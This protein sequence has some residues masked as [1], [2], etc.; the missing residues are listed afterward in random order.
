MAFN[1]DDLI[2]D[3]PIRATLFDKTTSEVIFT[4]DQITDPSLECTTQTDEVRDAI[5][6]LVTELDRA[7]E[8]VFSGTNAFINLG[9]MASQLGTTKQLASASVKIQVPKFEMIELGAESGTTN[10]TI[11]LSETPVGDIKYIYRLGNNK[12]IA[13][14]YEAGVT[15][16]DTFAI[17]G[18]VITL[19]TTP[20]FSANDRFGV[21]Y[22]YEATGAEGLGAV[23]VSNNSEAFTKI[24]VFDLEVLLADVCN[25][26]I[27][28]YAHILCNNAKMDGNTTIGFNSQATHGFTVK[29]FQDWCSSNKNLFDIIIPE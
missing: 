28:Y 10:K 18:K 13:E 8:S 26:N 24:G 3:R 4:I 6:S 2:I 29:L 23:K 9:L 25:S 22:K 7:K 11:T 19:P 15:A 20:T 12:S 21:W 16:T 17:A 27:K 1:L 5:G 14:K